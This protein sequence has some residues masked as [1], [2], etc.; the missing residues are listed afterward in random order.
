MKVLILMSFRHA[1]VATL[2]N[3]KEKVL[4][5]GIGLKMLIGE[6]IKPQTLIIN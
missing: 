4:K 1:E 2:I 6:R 5:E 3:S